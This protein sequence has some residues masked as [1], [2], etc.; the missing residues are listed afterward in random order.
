MPII[1]KAKNYSFSK[2]SI[3]NIAMVDFHLQKI[4]L[5]QHKDE[6]LFH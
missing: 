2:I 5:F 4:W 3:D 6:L 1:L